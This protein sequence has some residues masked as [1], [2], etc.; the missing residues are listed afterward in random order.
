M[1]EAVCEMF[2]RDLGAVIAAA[3]IAAAPRRA[4]TGVAL[5][6]ASSGAGAGVS[7]SGSAAAESAGSA[8]SVIEVGSKRRFDGIASGSSA[9]SEAGSIGVGA[10]AA[11]VPDV[12]RSRSLDSGEG[13]RSSSGGGGGAAH[14][15]AFC[16]DGTVV[17]WSWYV[18]AAWRLF[19]GEDGTCVSAA[20]NA[21]R[22]GH[23]QRILARVPQLSA[24]A[25]ALQELVLKLARP[26]AG[27][28]TA[29]KSRWFVTLSDLLAAM[30][31]PP[32]VEL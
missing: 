22:V 24:P 12:K 4:A 15:I 14:S 9:G 26:P 16:R 2:A 32:D 10:G 30:G 3:L 29:P 7:R 28:P 1:A 20:R 19:G 11:A 21:M 13:A 18:R 27:E 5:G 8:G 6:S 31:C 23:L 17:L 25:A